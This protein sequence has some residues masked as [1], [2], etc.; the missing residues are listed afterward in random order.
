[1][2]AHMY[3]KHIDHNSGRT[4]AH[5][6]PREFRDS[7]RFYLPK[8]KGYRRSFIR[9]VA[10]GHGGTYT[11]EEKHGEIYNA[12]KPRRMNSWAAAFDNVALY[13][14]NNRRCPRAPEALFSASCMYHGHLGYTSGRALHISR[15]VVAAVHTPVHAC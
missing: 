9:G 11:A 14:A 1:M 4:R 6:S 2:V 8:S 13:I 5:L 3:G 10:R 15:R 12:G 7:V